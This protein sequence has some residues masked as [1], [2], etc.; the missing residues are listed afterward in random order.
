M[1]ARTVAVVGVAAA[2]AAALGAHHLRDARA[3]MRRYSM[4]SVG[5]Y[6]LVTHLVFRGRYDEI[7]RAIA[8]EAPD[9][10]TVVDLGSGTGEV[11]VRLARLAPSLDLNGVDV[12]AAMVARAQGKAERATRA[13]GRRPAFVVADAGALP[14]PDDSVDLLVSS[15]AVH[16]LPDRHA[17]RAEILRVLKPG[18]RAIIWDV[19][20]PHGAPGPDA[21]AAPAEGHRGASG[22][23]HGAGA[24]D[25][26]RMLLTFGRIPA[27]RYELRKPGG[28]GAPA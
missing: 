18:A 5:L 1:R 26:V 24:L 15:Y 7:A 27:E 4:P 25:V 6:D 12:D 21:H 8:A 23:R 10:A 16:H 22:A 11:L 13:G 2:G 28:A 19:V 9:G 3:N 17:A 14:F 20:S